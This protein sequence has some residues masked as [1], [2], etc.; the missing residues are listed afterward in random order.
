MTT[1]E[2]AMKNELQIL[3]HAVDAMRAEN[4][5]L[6]RVIKEAAEDFRAGCTGIAIG[7]ISD[8]AEEIGVARGEHTNAP[9][10]ADG[11]QA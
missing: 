5:R 1:M 11:R 2:L 10:N 6:K 9:Q 7:R 8:A 3:R 4:R